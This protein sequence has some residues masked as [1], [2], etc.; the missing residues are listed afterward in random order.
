MLV[1]CENIVFAGNS[2]NTE[3]A[4]FDEIT[5]RTDELLDRFG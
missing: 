5:G 4:G 3:H 1:G 2:A